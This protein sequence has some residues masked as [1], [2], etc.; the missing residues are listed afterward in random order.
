MIPPT[1]LK[2]QITVNVTAGLRNGV[3]TQDVTDAILSVLDKAGMTT[4]PDI[5][6]RL[7]YTV[8]DPQDGPRAQ[9]FDVTRQRT[10]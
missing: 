8:H 3:P 9:H 4:T 2:Y 7:T 6:H 10:A 1:S 5:V